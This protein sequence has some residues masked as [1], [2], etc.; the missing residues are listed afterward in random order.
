MWV[1]V[2]EYIYEKN[3][4]AVLTENKKFNQDLKCVMLDEHIFDR[5][6]QAKQGI[7]AKPL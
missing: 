3:V 2:S 6:S 7:N 4:Q 5:C 1:S